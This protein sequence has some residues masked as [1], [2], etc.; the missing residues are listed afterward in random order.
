MEG[1]QR[2]LELVACRAPNMEITLGSWGEVF[3]LFSQALIINN[4]SMSI[5]CLTL[6][7]INTSSLTVT[8]RNYSP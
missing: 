8:V 2:S 3:F 6:A 4:C 5:D 7:I 1:S